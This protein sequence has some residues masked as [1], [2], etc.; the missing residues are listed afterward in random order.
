MKERSLFYP[1]SFVLVV[2]ICNCSYSR[3]NLKNNNGMID[4]M[5]E[6]ESEKAMVDE[7]NLQN[8]KSAMKEAT[9]S[10]AI[11]SRELKQEEL[12]KI[13]SNSP[14][15]IIK[16]LMYRILNGIIPDEYNKDDAFIRTLSYTLSLHYLKNFEKKYVDECTTIFE[17]WFLQ[18][19]KDPAISHTES[20]NE[21]RKQI[22]EGSFRRRFM[23]RL[24]KAN[25]AERAL[26]EIRSLDA[27]HAIQAISIES[28]QIAKE[29]IEQPSGRLKAVNRLNEL[30]ADLSLISANIE[31]V[32]EE[33][34]DKLLYLLGREKQMGDFNEQKRFVKEGMDPCI[35]MSSYLFVF[36][37]A[38]DS[39]NKRKLFNEMKE[40]CPA[41]FSEYLH[42]RE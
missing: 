38:R 31:R 32:E 8:G 19:L 22:L 1:F 29:V 2:F 11:D 12:L 30:D 5:K 23:R 14:A 28:L 42:C 10:E 6:K 35:S 26:L 16:I 4:G 37:S 25:S 15:D 33:S 21:V 40:K 39:V 36:I 3:Q 9:E 27:L 18:D 20:S 17:R 34:G 24:D 7:D 41:I 13:A